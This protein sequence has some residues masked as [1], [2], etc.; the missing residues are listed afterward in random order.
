VL[1]S[2]ALSALLTI[3]TLGS[4]DAFED[5]F[6]Y[7]ISSIRTSVIGDSRTFWHSYFGSP[8]PPSR[9]VSPKKVDRDIP[10]DLQ[11][12]IEG[13]V[14]LN[15]VLRVADDL[16]RASMRP[17]SGVSSFEGQASTAQDA[18]K[19]RADR[20]QLAQL[21]PQIVQPDDAI[22]WDTQPHFDM[23]TARP[24]AENERPHS[25]AY[26][27]DSAR[28]SMDGFDSHPVPA[29]VEGPRPSFDS[30]RSSFDEPADEHPYESRPQAR[31]YLSS[32][33]GVS[34]RSSLRDY[35]AMERPGVSR[36]FL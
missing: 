17:I 6:A 2:F 13:V 29:E 34:N 5:T 20:A 1:K 24:S 26:T 25:F 31:K 36:L 19:I 9:V 27:T 12:L 22:E 33:S 14:Q 28:S 21:V 15:E 23:V 3:C 16:E 30:G 4:L 11:D 10:D 35:L 8:A 7:D 32:C 18:I